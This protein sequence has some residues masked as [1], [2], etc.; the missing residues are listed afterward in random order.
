MSE[1]APTYLVEL[2]RQMGFLS[3][4]L[5]G[6]SGILLQIL[7]PATGP[8]RL[9]PIAIGFTVMAGVAFIIALTASTMIT[10]VLHPDA[11]AS[12]AEAS[13]VARA[14]TVASMSFMLGLYGLLVSLGLSGWTRSR[15]VGVAT[16]ILAGIGVIMVTWAVVGF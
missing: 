7:L 13:G 1:L 9:V 16:A 8:R 2:A 12:V 14:L 10:T 4:F 5:G 15:G 6:F 11:P 3:A